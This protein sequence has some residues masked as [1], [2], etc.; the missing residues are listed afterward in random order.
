MDRQRAIDYL[1]DQMADYLERQEIPTDGRTCFH[2]LNPQHEDRHP[3]MCYMRD[4]RKVHCFACNAAY[5]IFDLIGIDYGLRSFNEQ[6][7]KACE[8]YGVTID[9]SFSFTGTK[10][11][12]AATAETR[13]A[14]ATAPAPVPEQ[15]Q[16]AKDYSAYLQRCAQNIAGAE[17]YLASRGI[18]MEQARQH[19]LGYD[20]AFK[21][22]HTQQEWQ[23]LVIPVRRG[24]AGS[25][26]VVRNM[27]KE[28]DH[29]NRYRKRGPAELFNI[30]ALDAGPGTVIVTEGELDA[31]SIEAAGGRA[32]ALGSL[33]NK[34]LLLDAMGR[35]S[36]KSLPL[37]AVALDNDERGRAA[38]E[39][40]LGDLR[41][42]GFPAYALNL[43]GLCKDANELW[44]GASEVLKENVAAMQTEEGIN[45][46]IAYQDTAA[47]H[48]QDFINATVASMNESYV[49]TGFTRLDEKLDG[50]L[51]EGLYFLGAISS[52]GKTTLAL[53]IA[54]NIAE[55]GKDVL[56][57][58]LEMGRYELMA[59]SISRWTYRLCIKDP[60][61]KVAWAKTERGIR[62]GSRYASYREEEK[63]LIYEAI[64]K[65]STG[66]EHIYIH[67]GMGD[68]GVGE[69]RQRVLEYMQRTSQRPVVVVDYLQIIAPA[70]VRA[71]DKQNIDKAVLELK[72]LSRD[73]HLPILVI[74]SFNRENY[75]VT[76]S[77]RAF[78]ESGGIEYCSD[79]LMGMQLKG[80]EEKGF[81]V[82]EAKRKEP[83]EIELVILKQRSG[84]TGDRLGFY[85]YPKFNYFTEEEVNGRESFK[86]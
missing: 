74:S 53:Q 23:A 80:I 78:K 37:L 76:A 39:G 84:R 63:Q 54:D 58:S 46:F 85:Y 81:D 35:I 42:A 1:K 29:K 25:G 44:V 12:Q 73:Y 19:G 48:L 68:I 41:K 75:S 27:D 15:P 6:L 33:D 32:V 34:K 79:C 24:N 31:L 56:I 50:G 52:L 66:A 82:D 47:A 4:A 14:E 61:K 51:Y 62:T 69:I 17:E 40:L 60:E 64:Q 3:S 9:K 26:F 21:D 20:A 38:A 77:M 59:R 45:K 28:A 2:C 10:R 49:S 71:T 8:L 67:E 16:Q 30:A 57:F 70:D 7:A 36:K 65:Y 11:P 83:R 72:R 55:H 5:D 86:L 43:Y 22:Y 13:K 18:S